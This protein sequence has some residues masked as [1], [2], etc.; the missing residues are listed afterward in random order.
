MLAG[1][2]D[3]LSGPAWTAREPLPGGDFPADAQADLIEALRAEYDFLHER[4]AVRIGRAYGTRAGRW[5]GGARRWED[6]GRQ[7]GA[8]LSEAE[9]AYLRAEEWA[10]TAEDVLWRRSKLGLHMTE[11]ERDA[12]AA[13]M[14]C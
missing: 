8:G 9:I 7:F 11:P 5:L 14:G 10:V 4:D 3:G 12:V 13:Y 2:L 6:L 1:R